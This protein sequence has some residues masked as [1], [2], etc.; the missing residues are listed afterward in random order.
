MERG[1]N[2]EWGRDGE[3]GAVRSGEEGWRGGAVRS[4]EGRGGEGVQ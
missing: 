4:G 3:G 1:C 2:E